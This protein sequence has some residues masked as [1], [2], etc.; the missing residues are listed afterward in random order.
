MFQLC[1]GSSS[2]EK[3]IGEKCFA[4][5]RICSTVS[6]EHLNWKKREIGAYAHVFL[7]VADK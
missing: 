5:K 4:S 7:R 6:P 2:K 1:G 3:M